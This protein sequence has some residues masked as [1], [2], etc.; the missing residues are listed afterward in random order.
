MFRFTETCLIVSD[1]PR[2]F[3]LIQRI[4]HMKISYVTDYIVSMV[5]LHKKYIVGCNRLAIIIESLEQRGFIES[6]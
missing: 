4:L 2:Y 6:E 3:T 1:G 5:V